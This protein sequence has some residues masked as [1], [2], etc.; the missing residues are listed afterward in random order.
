MVGVA[1]AEFGASIWYA[2]QRHPYRVPI[3]EEEGM[4][5]KFTVMATEIRAAILI[6]YEAAA[7]KDRGDRIDLEAGITKL[8]AS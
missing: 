2:Q 6:A 5:F 7:K 8:L 1:S 3:A 4:K